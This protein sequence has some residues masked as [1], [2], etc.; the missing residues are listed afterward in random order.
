MTSHHKIAVLVACTLV[1]SGCSAA[2]P[3][4]QGEDSATLSRV[5]WLGFLP[6]DEVQAGEPGAAVRSQAG[7]RALQG[8]VARLRRR[9]A[10][11]RA[12]VDV[13]Q[14]RLHELNGTAPRS[15]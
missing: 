7:I 5:G 15:R 4:V 3:P 14:K 13:A 8:R 11:L 12:P 1:L 2:I 6:L 10:I 9:A